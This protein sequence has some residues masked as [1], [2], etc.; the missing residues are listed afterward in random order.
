MNKISLFIA[1]SIS[2]NFLFSV[3]CD[4]ATNLSPGSFCTMNNLEADQSGV[5]TYILYAGTAWANWSY[6][7]HPIFKNAQCTVVAPSQYSGYSGDAIVHCP[8]DW[9][10]NGSSCAGSCYNQ[11]AYYNNQ[12]AGAPPTYQTACPL[13]SCSYV[14]LG[15]ACPEGVIIM[16]SPPPYTPTQIQNANLCIPYPN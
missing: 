9:F 6:P 8:S 12:S 3:A 11:A 5:E 16:G 4:Q 1:L 14:F 13:G 7:D 15:A 10:D 2:G